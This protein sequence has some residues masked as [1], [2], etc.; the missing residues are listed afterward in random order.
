MPGFFLGSVL[1]SL[2]AET[3]LENLGMWCGAPKLG[4]LVIVMAE[5]DQTFGV[6][7]V[8]A[9]QMFCRFRF[10]DVEGG[11]CRRLRFFYPYVATVWFLKLLFRLFL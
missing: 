4:F 1:P 11:L 3:V 10:V 9:I 8:C 7:V 2:C 6:S 5:G